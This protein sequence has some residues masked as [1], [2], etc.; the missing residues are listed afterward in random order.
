MPIYEYQAAGPERCCDYCREAFDVVQRLADAPL[1]ACPKCG[2]PVGKLISA[3]AAIQSRGSL[4][5]RAKDA[6]F[7]KLKRVDKGVYEKK[8]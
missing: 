6:G 4:D 3:P 7:H 5:S 2:A 1:A 8:Y